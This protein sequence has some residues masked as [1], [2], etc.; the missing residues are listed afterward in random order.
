MENQIAPA[1][2]S[3]WN[4]A[5]RFLPNQYKDH[6]TSVLM[7]HLQRISVHTKK[8][9]GWDFCIARVHV[10]ILPVFAAGSLFQVSGRT[11]THFVTTIFLGSEKEP[12]VKEGVKVEKDF[13]LSDDFKELIGHVVATAIIVFTYVIPVGFLF[14]GMYQCEPLKDLPQTQIEKEL[15]EFKTDNQAAATKAARVNTAE[16]SALESKKAMERNKLELLPPLSPKSMVELIKHQNS[17]PDI[18]WMQYS[19]EQYDEYSQ[20]TWGLPEGEVNQKTT[21]VDTKPKD[22][23]LF[24]TPKG[25]IELTINLKE[26]SPEMLAILLSKK[27]QVH[28]LKLIG[29]TLEQ[30]QE[31]DFK[32]LLNTIHTLILEQASGQ[33]AYSSGALLK[34]SKRYPTIACFDLSKCQFDSYET[35]K[36]LIGDFASDEGIGRVVIYPKFSEPATL[37]G[38]DNIDETLSSFNRLL[39]GIVTQYDPHSPD[40]FLRAFPEPG[41][42]LHPAAPFMTRM[43]FLAGTKIRTMHLETLLIKIPVI[44][45]HLESLDLERC[46]YLESGTFDA[47]ANLAD[48]VDLKNLYLRDCEAIYYRRAEKHD[49]LGTWKSADYEHVKDKDRKYMLDINLAISGINR[50]FRKGVDRIRLKRVAKGHKKIEVIDEKIRTEVLPLI[51]QINN[52]KFRKLK[53]CYGNNYEHPVTA[54]N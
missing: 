35:F 8:E 1:F 28:R 31:E 22:K 10:F 43:M 19:G 17:I 41:A 45:P 32:D 36:P 23:G 16:A 38:S 25:T 48:H 34:L 33:A 3:T 14:A 9:G 7:D 21:F 42:L 2:C 52:L 5:G 37:N 26:V 50:L 39:H 47:V 44:F 46:A 51:D 18:T 27:H 29:A 12:V 53:I 40:S 24:L 4:I 11:F 6:R 20:P 30:L 54:K 49:D 15:T 13:S